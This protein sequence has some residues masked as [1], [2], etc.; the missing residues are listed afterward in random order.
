MQIEFN[1]SGCGQEL[2]VKELSV[3]SIG[4]IEVEIE[5]C[6]NKDCYVCGDCEEVKAREKAEEELKK[7]KEDVIKIL[8]KNN[9][10]NDR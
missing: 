3:N 9:E 10:T 5:T 8:Q 2:K 4:I 1:C 7:V 6:H